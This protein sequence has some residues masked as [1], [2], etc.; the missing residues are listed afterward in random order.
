MEE[1]FKKLF[2]LREKY[3]ITSEIASQIGG[4]V[5]RP[6][7]KIVEPGQTINTEIFTFVESY[8]IND[9]SLLE[10]GRIPSKNRTFGNT[11]SQAG[12]F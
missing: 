12:R 1:I 7:L 6:L 9:S 4:K 5:G 10:E 8:R 3:P 11:K 2:E